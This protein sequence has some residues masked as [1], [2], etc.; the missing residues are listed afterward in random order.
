MSILNKL[1]LIGIVFIVGCGSLG[2]R[3]DAHSYKDPLYGTKPIKKIVVYANIQNMQYRDQIESAFIDYFISLNYDCIAVKSSTMILP[4]RT[5]TNKELKEIFKS[6][7]IDALL[8]F[9]VQDAGYNHQQFTYNQPYQT[10]GNVYKSGSNSYSYNAYTYGGPQTYNFYKPYL[11]A[12]AD[13]YDVNT[14]LKIWTV[15]LNSRGNAF[16]NID[17][18]LYKSIKTSVLKLEQ[19]GIIKSQKNTQGY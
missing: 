9:T 7:S 4:T 5:Y 6:N 14:E 10:Y 15:Q 19:D 1:Y 17:D 2:V 18:A 8:V 16:A 11:S 12:V 3:T 13:L